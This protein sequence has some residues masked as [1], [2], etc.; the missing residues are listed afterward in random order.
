MYLKGKF[1]QKHNS[2]IKEMLEKK[3]YS[4]ILEEEAYDIIKYMYNDEDAK[5][6]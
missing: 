6:L 3:S 1:P 5:L 4:I 2:E